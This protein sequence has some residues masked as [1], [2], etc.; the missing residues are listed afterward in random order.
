MN[1]P[2]VKKLE[3]RLLPEFEEVIKQIKVR[4]PRVNTYITA[5]TVGSLTSYQGYSFYIECLFDELED[6]TDSVFFGV[7]LGHLTTIPKIDASSGWGQ[8]FGETIT[9]FR[10]W[11]GNFPTDG[12]IVSDEVLEE[13]YKDLPRHYDGLLKALEK[14]KTGEIK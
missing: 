10:D 9:S 6:E 7:C 1:H 4:F 14:V 5:S 2:L 3:E 12:I 8:P 11:S 13:L